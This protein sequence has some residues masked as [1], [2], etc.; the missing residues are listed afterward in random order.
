MKAKNIRIV[1]IIQARTSSTRLPNKVLLPLPYNSEVT[2]LQQV[3]RRVKRSSSLDD[4]VIAT[5]KEKEDEKIVEIAKKENVN[6]FKGSKND[7]LSRYYYAAKE[8]KADVIVRI[9]SDCPCID[10]NIIDSTIKKHINED[11]DYTSNTAGRT[12]PRGLDVEAISFNAL[13]KAF[14][15]ADKDFEREHVCPYIYITHKDEFKI[16]SLKA[17][18]KL[19]APDIR[20]TLDTREDYALL[21]AVFDF[22][23]GKKPF[24]DAFDIIDLFKRKPWLKFINEKVLQKKIF[25]TIKKEIEEAKRLLELQDLK[26]AKEI[27]GKWKR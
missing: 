19:T 10:W 23:Y 3:I 16:E 7:V 27:L 8:N 24:F 1:S 11:V 21:C 14:F 9:T 4:I 12:F 17:P 22:L 5:T 6:F 25:N 18:N 15:E 26:N 13:E 2:V 20:I